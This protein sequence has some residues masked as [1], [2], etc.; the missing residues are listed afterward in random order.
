MARLTDVQRAFL[1]GVRYGYQLGR[2]ETRRN[3]DDLIGELKDSN[4]EVRTEL[5]RL[6]AIKNIVDTE[7]DPDARL[8]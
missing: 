1:A 6:R 4:A 8:N 5:A 7:R 2:K 3:V